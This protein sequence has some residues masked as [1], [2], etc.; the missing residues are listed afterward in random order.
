MTANHPN[1]TAWLV[2]TLLLLATIAAPLNQFKVAPLMPILMEQFSLSVGTAGLLMSVFA[3]TGLVLSLPAGFIVQ[4]I[5]YRFTGTLA[6][7]AVALGTAIGALSLN[8]ETLLASRVIEGVG[9]SFIAVMA[10]ALIA[11]WFTDPPARD[12]DGHLWATGMPIGSMSIF[13]IAPA[14][15]GQGNWQRVWWFG[16]VYAVVVGVLFLVFMKMPRRQAAPDGEAVVAGHSAGHDMMH[17]LR[18]RDLWL[19]GLTFCCLNVA[20]M[21]FLTWTPTYLNTV[22]GMSLAEAASVTS[23]LPLL[24]LVSCPFGGWLSDRLGSRKLII[25]IPLIIL[26]LVWPLMPAAAPT[27]IIILTVIIGWNTGFIATGLFATG[28]QLVTNERLSGMAVGVIQVGMNAGL[29]LGP[30]VFGWLV[31]AGGWSAAFTALTPVC[32]A[33]AIAAL[34]IRMK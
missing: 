29:V 6:V 20:S 2:V 26:A 13:L 27:A 3:I 24:N 21:G 17:V 16:F 10:P 15:A 22:H 28:P 9:N 11:L 8:A 34:A 1:R 12:S 18:N 7:G 19:A 30:L 4:K 33:G 32:A 31:E 14:L 23:I 5:G 25:V